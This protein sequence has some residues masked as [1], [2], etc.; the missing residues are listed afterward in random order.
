M[1]NGISNPILYTDFYKFGHV[2]QYR[3]GISRILTNWTPRSSRVPGQD[4]VVACAG[5][6][7][8]IQEVLLGWFS[9][10]FFNTPLAQIRSQ[11]KNVCKQCLG[12]EDA[13]SSHIEDLWVLG[14][15][16]IKI[17]ALPEG[18]SVGLRVP[19]L[20]MVNTDPRFFWLPNYFET[21][22]SAQLW[23]T[24]T[25]ATTAQRFRKIMVAAA[26]R[27]YGPDADL[28]FVDWQGHDFSMRGMFGVDAARLSGLGHLFSFKGTDTVPA[29]LAT[30]K[31]YGHGDGNLAG[32]GG[33][34]PATEHSVMCAGGQEGEYETFE[35][36]VTEIYPTG[37]VSIV[38]DTWDLWKVLTDYVPRL[39]E[40]ILARPNGKVVIRPDSG[41]PAKIILGDSSQPW[42][43][44]AYWGVARLLC[45][46]MGQ[47]HGM[48]N[49]VGMIYGD[50]ITPERC[51][52]ILQGLISY[53]LSPYNMVFGIGSYTYQMVT[54]D[55]Y[56]QAMKATACWLEDG[57]VVEI[58]KKPVTDDG[59]KNSARGI[60]A[61]Y[62][63]E[64]S[65]EERPDY[66]L[67]E[68]A[69]EAQLDD[70]AFELVFKDG[71]QLVRPSLKTIRERVQETC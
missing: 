35:R 6:S 41:D 25:S 24:I 16:P 11:Y 33:S 26:Q 56:G 8:F 49:S 14:Y 40:Q 5:L 20:C 53:G 13:N 3:K 1:D 18:T 58:W 37:I 48:L 66:F 65:T 63:T 34:V 36:L 47:T 21:I 30:A 29:I 39:R 59:M 2:H 7:A 52:A 23:G 67:V 38:S 43:T 31:Y 62:R 9:Q 69:T 45:D 50:A 44:P 54:R 32:V 17:Y 15:L 70:C 22:L 61:V 19:I 71:T 12:I 46:A 10:H 42:G 4:H 57:S 64:E 27:Y 28:G 51:E 55:T 60:L 68:Q